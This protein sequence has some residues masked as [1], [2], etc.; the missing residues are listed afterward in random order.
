MN[1]KIKKIIIN[2]IIIIIIIVLFVI[3][4]K[5]F[6]ISNK[7]KT[8]LINSLE[9]IESF[10]ILTPIIFGLIYIIC[11]VLLISGAV[12][13]LGAG[14]IFGVIKGSI[15][16]SV[17]STLAAITSFLI[18]R[19]LL[20]NWVLKKIEK[21]PKFKAVDTAVAK[22]G[23]KIVGL[24]RLSPIFPFI[25]L[26]YAFGLTKI[27][28]KDYSIASWIGMLPGT[29]MYVYIGSLIGDI[30]TLGAGGREKTPIEWIFTIIGLII[31][32]AVTF[33]VTYISKKAL[34]KKLDV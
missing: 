18:G 25:F 31:T 7:I 28:L 14:I 5:Y 4:N 34:S 12:L 15:I 32:V 11:T 6:N 22:E 24:T 20:R 21:Y 3:L 29:I 30:A 16:V 2:T 26:N 1:N 8:V 27:S 19:F 10:G 17:F 33:Y 23:W 13:T 9:W